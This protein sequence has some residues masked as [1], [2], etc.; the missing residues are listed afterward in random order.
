M[1]SRDSTMLTKSSTTEQQ[2]WQSSSL[3]SCAMFAF[4][5]VSQKAFG[6]RLLSLFA[7]LWVALTGKARCSSNKPHS[8]SEVERSRNNNGKAQPHFDYIQNRNQLQYM[9]SGVLRCYTEGSFKYLYPPSEHDANTRW[10][11]LKSWIQWLVSW[12]Q[13]N[14]TKRKLSIS[15]EPAEPCTG[16]SFSMSIVISKVQVVGDRLPAP[17]QGGTFQPP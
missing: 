17:S 2:P 12:K 7:G 14:R 6:T 3:P 4:I 13:H 9:W 10:F 15:S 11:G 8:S 16:K 5:C 1:E